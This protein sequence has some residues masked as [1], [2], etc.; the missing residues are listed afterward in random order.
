MKI[1]LDANVL[2]SASL[3]AA[4]AAQALLVTAQQ[5]GAQS[6]TSELAFAEARRNLESKAAQSLE[7]LNLLAQVIPRASEPGAAALDDARTAGVADKDVP[8]LAAALAAGADWFVTGDMR[9]FGHLYG[10]RVEGV[11]VLPLRE[12]IDALAAEPPPRAARGRRR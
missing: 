5:V 7:N 10:R 9:H 6:I 2:F 1:F 12:A 4:G 8:I 11:L 3:S